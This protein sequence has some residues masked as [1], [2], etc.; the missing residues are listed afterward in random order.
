MTNK[1][2]LEYLDGR[3]HVRT[4][5]ELKREAA[6]QAIARAG[7]CWAA[8]SESFVRLAAAADF[9]AAQVSLLGR[10]LADPEQPPKDPRLQALAARQRQGKGPPSSMGWRGRERNTKYRSQS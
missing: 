4:R 2:F 7:A 1:L 6:R 9:T 8:G 3:I 10:A 5:Q